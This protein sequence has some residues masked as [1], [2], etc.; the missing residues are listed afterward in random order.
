MPAF[1]AQPVV[2]SPFVAQVPELVV[3]EPLVAVVVEL[4]PDGRQ[5]GFDRQA[6]VPHIGPCVLFKVDSGEE[7][8]VMV[9]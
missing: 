6:G 5:F 3:A 7:G 9:D 1:V 4:P 8:A 2:A